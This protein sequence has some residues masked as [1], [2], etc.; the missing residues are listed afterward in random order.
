MAV[1]R[2]WPSSRRSGAITLRR[3]ADFA[4]IMLVGSSP[5]ILLI[6]PGLGVRSMT[7][8]VA[9]ARS[10]PGSSAVPHTASVL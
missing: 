1:Q 2:S 7:E 8:L 5:A 4:P 6:D 9:L 10:K 3:A